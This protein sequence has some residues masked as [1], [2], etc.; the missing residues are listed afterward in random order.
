MSGPTKDKGDPL[1]P[2]GEISP[3]VSAWDP[4]EDKRL[5]QLEEARCFRSEQILDSIL[6]ALD[7]RSGHRFR[8]ERG[9]DRTE[10]FETFKQGLLD[11]DRE[12]GGTIQALAE[13]VQHANQELR[14]N[15]PIYHLGPRAIFPLGHHA[16]DDAW[17]EGRKVAEVSTYNVDPIWQHLAEKQLWRIPSNMFWSSATVD[18]GALSKDHEAL[19]A[20]AG[21]PIT[22]HHDL[23]RGR[24]VAPNLYA[25]EQAIEA[26]LERMPDQEKLMEAL[27]QNR[28]GYT[29]SY[30][31]VVFYRNWFNSDTHKGAGSF[32]CIN[33]T[34]AFD[35]SYCVE[36]QFLT[37]NMQRFSLL[38][39]ALNFRKNV[40]FPDAESKEWLERLGL[41]V[42]LKDLGD[43]MSSKGERALNALVQA[44]VKYWLG[45]DREDQE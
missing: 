18:V 7:I 27:S 38:D 24:I 10:T 1:L 6:E 36:I 4:V 37:L 35:P 43:L 21:E 22:K 12:R 20:K 45:G 33:F 31:R 34:I 13:S 17:F 32:R 42:Q 25:L 8:Y 14:S 9:P 30:P 5:R 40:Q 26:L 28:L 41:V 11:L 3:Q 16:R 29:G 15:S 2:H 39:H 23:V 19:A 44:K